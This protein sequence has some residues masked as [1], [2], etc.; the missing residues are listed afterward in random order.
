M[1]SVLDTTPHHHTT[2]TL[3]HTIPST[4]T[5]THH[6]FPCICPGQRLG[7]VH[8]EL[9]VLPSTCDY[10][11]YQANLACLSCPRCLVSQVSNP[12]QRHLHSLS[13]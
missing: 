9:L 1:Y 3:Q 8:L 12:A 4:S 11:Y 10:D 13:L 7:P 5:D 2:A 6:L